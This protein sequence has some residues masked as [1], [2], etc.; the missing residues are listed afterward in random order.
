MLLTYY[1]DNRW[2]PLAQSATMHQINLEFSR[3][4]ASNVRTTK[5]KSKQRKKG[6]KKFIFRLGNTFAVLA[7]KRE[8]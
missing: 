5:T 4:L 7:Q 6:Q 2:D 8:R 1:R 3:V